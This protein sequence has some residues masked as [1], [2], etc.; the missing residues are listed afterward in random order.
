VTEAR[1]RPEDPRQRK[2]EIQD[3][4][5]N[6]SKA[7]SVLEWAPRYGFQQAITWAVAWYRQ[8][9]RLPVIALSPEIVPLRVE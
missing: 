3:Q 7:R 2:P 8:Q 4:F 1:P 6:S 9:L 5:L